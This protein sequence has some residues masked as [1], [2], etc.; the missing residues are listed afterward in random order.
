MATKSILFLLKS[1]LIFFMGFL[2]ISC[3]SKPAMAPQDPTIQLPTKSGD[4]SVGGSSAEESVNVPQFVG[5]RAPRVGLI[6]GPGG[7][8]TVAQIGVLQELEKNK[9]PVTAVVGMEWGAV[10]GALFAMNGQSHEADWKISQLPK[11][12]FSSKN[13]FSQKMRPADKKEFDSFLQKVFLSARID[14]SKIPF[15]CPSLRAPS[16]RVAMISKGATKTMLRSCWHY[17]PVFDISD[18]MA[19]P[20]AIHEAVSFLK[21]QGAE[22]IVLI[23]VLDSADKKQF[24]DWADSDWNWLAWLPVLNSLKNAKAAGV[25]EVITIDTSTYS[26]SDLGQR[27]RLIQLGKQGA[28]SSLEQIVKKYDF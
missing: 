5:D 27:L 9:I 12:S 18:S 2:L 1:S 10:V 16:G 22:L 4:T 26:M 19:A 11:F 25:H 23:N 6:F 21:S 24:A 8:K 14:Q 15:A 3:Q 28:A 17:P 7:A 20:F 13:P